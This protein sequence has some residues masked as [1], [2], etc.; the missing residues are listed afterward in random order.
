[1]AEGSS[2]AQKSVFKETLLLF[3]MH[4]N[5]C[6]IELLYKLNQLYRT[7][8]CVILLIC[9]QIGSDEQTHLNLGMPD[10]KEIYSFLGALFLEYINYK[11]MLFFF[12]FLHLC[13]YIK[14]GY[15]I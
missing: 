3:V 12:I 15:S 8:T 4:L 13:N 10:A 5:I 14:N 2:P 7:A 6:V 11:I 9:L 1:M